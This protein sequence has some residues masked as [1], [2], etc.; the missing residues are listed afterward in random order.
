MKGGPDSELCADIGLGPLLEDNRG[1]PSRQQ[2]ADQVLKAPNGS[3]ELRGIGAQVLEFVRIAGS[4]AGLSKSLRDL[5]R[6]GVFL[7]G[8]ATIKNFYCIS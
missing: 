4:G 3:V 6:E 8:S 5:V 2:L 7:L 1:E